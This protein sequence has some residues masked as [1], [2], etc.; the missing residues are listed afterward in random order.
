MVILVFNYAGPHP[1]PPPMDSHESKINGTTGIY[2]CVMSII[3]VI[4]AAG[5]WMTNV[6]PRLGLA[7]D[8]LHDMGYVHTSKVDGMYVLQLR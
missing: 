5:G 4:G 6:R 3:Y 7:S 2:F 8:T 1:T